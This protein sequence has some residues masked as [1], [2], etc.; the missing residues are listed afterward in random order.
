[1]N[2]LGTV[3]YAWEEKDS[4]MC[5]MLTWLSTG[6]MVQRNSESKLYLDTP[7]T[8]FNKLPGK[9]YFILS[10][11]SIYYDVMGQPEGH[12]AGKGQITFV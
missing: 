2:I 10:A 1:M 11:Q 7:S 3:D 9:D 5:L 6:T 8:F 4:I 12:W